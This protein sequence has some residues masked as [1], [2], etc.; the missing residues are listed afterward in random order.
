MSRKDD[1]GMAGME[2]GLVIKLR[3]NC[4]A[5]CPDEIR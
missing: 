4:T 3:W 5:Q 1:W 2:L